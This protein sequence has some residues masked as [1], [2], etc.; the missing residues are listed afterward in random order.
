MNSNW[1]AIWDYLGI[2]SG[3]QCRRCRRTIGAADGFGR[4]E[5]VCPSCR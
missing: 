3:Q 2:R 4:S 1:S 5:G